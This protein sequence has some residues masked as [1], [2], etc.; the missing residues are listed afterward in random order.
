MLMA[1]TQLDPSAL[2]PQRRGCLN[3]VSIKRNLNVI[4]S[5]EAT[6]QPVTLAYLAQ[7]N[8]RDHVHRWERDLPA[9]SGWP[10]RAPA[11]RGD[12][13]AGFLCAGLVKL[14]TAFFVLAVSAA[15]PV[16]KS[17]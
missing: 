8:R 4:M 9:A 6:T 17:Q 15:F 3:G 12:D 16:P 11:E 7:N 5:S 10:E 1:S 14:K 13:R 2:M